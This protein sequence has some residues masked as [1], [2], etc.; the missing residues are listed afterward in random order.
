MTA[1]GKTFTHLDE[2]FMVVSQNLDGSFICRSL[3]DLRHWRF[4]CDELRAI[5]WEQ[6]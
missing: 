1:I 6:V 3:R 5:L 2:V 4:S